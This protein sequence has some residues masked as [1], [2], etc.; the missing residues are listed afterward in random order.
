MPYQAD[1]LLKPVFSATEGQ[2]H[3]IKSTDHVSIKNSMVRLFLWA[4]VYRY[5][6]GY[7]D[8]ELDGSFFT[9]LSLESKRNK[10]QVERN[11]S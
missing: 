1:I 11:E 8:Q 5:S 3:N 4:H 6:P 9:L 10:L 7:T 2:Y